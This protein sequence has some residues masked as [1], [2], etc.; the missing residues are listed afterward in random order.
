MTYHP[1]C[2]SLRMLRAGDRPT[3][4]LRAVRGLE[5]VPLPRA[6]ECCGFGG[7]FAHPEVAGS[8]PGPAT[9][10]EPQVRGRF[11]SHP[12][13]AS[14]AFWEAMS[15]RCLRTVRGHRLNMAPKSVRGCKRRSG[16]DLI[17]RTDPRGQRSRCHWFRGS[18]NPEVLQWAA[19]EGRVLVTHDIRTISDFAHERVSAGLLMPGVI[20]VRPV[21]P[22]AVVIDE[23]VIIEAASDP[24]DWKGGV[25]YLPLL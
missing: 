5:L 13:A 3:R 14:D 18:G 8:N 12:E 16:K 25:H 19:D 24:E 17:A 15:V 6:E 11:R 20:I 10:A 2:Y 21:L 1:T 23:L 9:N 7:T 4:L 22:I